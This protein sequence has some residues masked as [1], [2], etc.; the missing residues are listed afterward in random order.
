MIAGMPADRN[1]IDALEQQ[2][3]LEE[4][5]VSPVTKAA[6]TLSSY[7]PLPWPFRAIK[8]YAQRQALERMTLMIETCAGELRKHEQQLKDLEAKQSE[9]ESQRRSAVAADLYVDALRKAADTRSRER[10]KRIGLILANGALELAPDDADEIEEMMRIAMELGDDEV[11]HLR[12]LVLIQGQQVRTERLTQYSAHTLWGQGTWGTR[13]DHEVDSVF[14][15]L[16]SYGL[17]TRLRP[18]NNLSLLG[19]VPNRYMLLRKGLRFSD[20]VQQ[21]AATV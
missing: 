6:M 19:E 16:E 18:P 8:D 7:L 3:Q 20:L 9:Q 14:S 12:E 15:K 13:V 1:P 17:V 21:T 2:Y 5:T 11:L 4:T 10:V